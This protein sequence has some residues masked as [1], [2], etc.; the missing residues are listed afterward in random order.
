M[1]NITIETI[2]TLYADE[3]PFEQ[4]ITFKLEGTKIKGEYIIIKLIKEEIYEGENKPTTLTV[5]MKEIQDI[6]E[7]TKRFETFAQTGLL[8]VEGLWGVSI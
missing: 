5:N 7:L 1:K 6:E 3:K 8:P 2:K 4:S